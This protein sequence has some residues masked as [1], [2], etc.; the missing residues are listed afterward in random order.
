MPL[1]LKLDDKGQPTITE[2]QKIMYVDDDGKDLPLDPAGMYDKITSLGVQNKKDR[3]KY[4]ELRDT[5]AGFKDIED[6]ADWKTKADAALVSVENFDDKDWMK[7]DK[8]EKLKSDMVSAYD[9]KLAGKDTILATT[10][11]AHADDIAGK[12]GQIRTLMVTNKF[13][14]SP[15]FVG[16]NKITTLPPDIG[17]AYFGKHYKVEVNEKGKSVLRSYYENGEAILSKV[18]PGEPADFEESLGFIIEAYPGKDNIL[19]STSGGSG[20]QGGQGNPNSATELED[21]KTQH[22]EAQKVGNTQ[23]MI[24]LKNKIFE[25]QQKA[26]K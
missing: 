25:L 7:A 3:T 2:D 22:A 10:V 17:E 4:T 5:Y 16:E 9:L 14:G 11:K 20:G 8:V 18:N 1:V 6:I 12:D 19:T 13:A 15:H 26:P 21:L 24:S 23:L